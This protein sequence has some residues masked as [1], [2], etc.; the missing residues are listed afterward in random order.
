MNELHI[1]LM[2]DYRK[3]NNLSTVLRGTEKGQPRD[4]RGTKRKSAKISVN[5]CQNAKKRNLLFAD[6]SISSFL[7]V[8]SFADFCSFCV[9]QASP[10]VYFVPPKFRRYA[11]SQRFAFYR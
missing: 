7:K 6:V 5:K 4:S 10:E 9:P 3:A 11:D 8:V 1:P 2:T